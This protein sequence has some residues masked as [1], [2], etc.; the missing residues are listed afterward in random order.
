[1]GLYEIW[2]KRVNDGRAT[3]AAFLTDDYLPAGA[4]QADSLKE[5]TSKLHGIKEDDLGLLGARPLRVGD[6]VKDPNGNWWI[7]TF[8]LVWAGVLVFV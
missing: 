8:N 4:M 6:V 5:L 1:M 2:Y 7:C 3:E